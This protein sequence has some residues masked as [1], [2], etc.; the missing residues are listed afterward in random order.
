MT[1]LSNHFFKNVFSISKLPTIEVAVDQ[2]GDGELKHCNLQ[3]VS[4]CELVHALI[5]AC[6]RD[7]QGIIDTAT[8]AELP[9]DDDMAASQAAL[10]TKWIQVLTSVPTKFKVLTT[11][12]QRFFA[13][14]QA[15]IDSD[16]EAKSIAR[17]PA[18]WAMEV[19]L[20][21]AR[22]HRESGSRHPPGAA[23]VS[24]DLAKNLN[25][26]GTHGD[27]T[28]VY[29]AMTKTFVDNCLTIHERL[30]KH[31]D[32]LRI[33]MKSRL[34]WDK[35]NKL[36]ALV[37]KAGSRENI[38]W[39]LECT[40]DAI[41]HK[42]M[43]PD[44]VSGRALKGGEGSVSLAHVLIARRQLRD[45]LFQVAQKDFA[46]GW[47]PEVLVQM[48]QAFSSVPSFRASMQSLT[49]QRGFLPSQLQFVELLEELLSTRNLD[50]SL[51]QRLI[52]K[53]GVCDWVERMPE[54]ET[55]MAHIKDAF[56]KE[57]ED[58]KAQEPPAAGQEAS[59]VDGCQPAECSGMIVDND[60]EDACQAV[61]PERKLAA[62]LFPKTPFKE[63]DHWMTQAARKVSRT[64]D[65]FVEP[66]ESHCAT[67]PAHPAKFPP[68]QPAT[69]PFTHPRLSACVNNPTTHPPIHPTPP[70]NTHPLTP[71]I[72]Y[73]TIQHPSTHPHT[74]RH[75][76][77]P[78]PIQQLAPT[79]HTPSSNTHPAPIQLALTNMGIVF[80]HT[81]LLSEQSVDARR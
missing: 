35:V 31:P 23:A 69:H 19:V 56:Q 9:M 17:K 38:K 73:A 26:S 75:N 2:A 25:F 6:A 68:S 57:T 12:S 33:V 58:A 39:V 3:R 43:S 71:S 21:Q 53:E 48:Q 4:P 40:Q 8:Q 16:V 24:E 13:S 22:M 50:K 59:K 72:H 5:V 80:V 51:R 34:P 15:R 41:E 14:V 55:A 74:Q 78:A 61:T 36:W 45:Q 79:R 64:C 11:E 47:K 67:N 77:H 18:Q 63:V 60:D 37:Y 27:E 20:H 66:Q 52:N 7:M 44:D 28:S 10:K 1:K 70:Y 65:L 62:K 49:W 32:M 29:E 54:I 30:L 81:R 42:I 46:S 76:T